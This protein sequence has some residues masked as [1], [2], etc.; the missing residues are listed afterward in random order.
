[1]A[2][3]NNGT[4]TFT[5]GGTLTI[6]SGK[7]LYFLT[8]CSVTINSGTLA[9][10][11]SGNCRLTQSGAGKGIVAQNGTVTA[12]IDIDGTNA[13]AVLVAGT[14][15]GLVTVRNNGT[16]SGTW[17]PSA[18][19]YTFSAGLQIINDNASTNWILLGFPD[20]KLG[21]VGYANTY[22]SPPRLVEAVRIITS[23]SVWIGQQLMQRLI[24]ETMP[25]KM[26]DVEVES[27]DEETGAVNIKAKEPVKFLGFIKGKATK[28]FNI[29]AEGK[30]E[31]KAPWYRF[32]Y[33]EEKSE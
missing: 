19:T 24:R 5:N 10:I 26:E 9:S 2:A 12:A 4:V 30:I 15:G 3:E 17:T 28:R 32:M 23:G 8:G 21:V 6:N 25:Q 13:A 33:A 1:L 20:K 18:G 22:I 7:I 29:N 14:Y 16:G 11:G 27:V 31:E